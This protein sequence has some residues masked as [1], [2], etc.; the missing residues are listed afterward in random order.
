MT[1]EKLAILS[2]LNMNYLSSI[3]R[4]ERSVGLLKIWKLAEAL[5]ISPAKF[6]EPA[7]L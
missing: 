3:E 2:G 1:Q 4:G 5:E 6:F 7:V